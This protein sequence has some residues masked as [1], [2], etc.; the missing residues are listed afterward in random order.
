LT[1]FFIAAP[2]MRGLWLARPKAAP[3]AAE[4]MLAEGR[5]RWIGPFSL[6]IQRV[7]LLHGVIKAAKYEI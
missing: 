4:P 7:A 5:L 6:E 1:V 2:V 3:Q